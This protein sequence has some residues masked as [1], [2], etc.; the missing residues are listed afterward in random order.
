[1]VTKLTMVITA[2]CLKFKS[3]YCTKLIQC[4]MSIYL[5]KTRRKNKEEFKIKNKRL[6][7]NA[8]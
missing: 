6:M 1:M 3:L 5:N 4:Y 7:F 8:F 2:W